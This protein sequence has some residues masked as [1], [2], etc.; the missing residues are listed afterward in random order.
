M[1]TGREAVD[2]DSGQAGPKAASGTQLCNLDGAHENESRAARSGMLPI[3]DSGPIRLEDVSRVDLFTNPQG[4]ATVY[5]PGSLNVEGVEGYRTGPTGFEVG[6][7][8]Q[9]AGF[10]LQAGYH[11]GQKWRNNR[12]MMLMMFP[13]PS[14]SAH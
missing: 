6:P 7:S 11:G 3:E 12:P 10:R 14:S 13:W 8:A 2:T 9:D 4:I 5:G 1:R